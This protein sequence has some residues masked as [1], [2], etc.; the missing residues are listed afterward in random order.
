MCI[1]TANFSP[2]MQNYYTYMVHF[3][4]EFRSNCHDYIAEKVFSTHRHY[5]RGFR[6]QLN[7]T[8][9]YIQFSWRYRYYGYFRLYEDIRMWPKYIPT[10]FMPWKKKEDLVRIGLVGKHAL[11]WK[12]HHLK[13]FLSHGHMY[14]SISDK[15]M[16]KRKSDE[17]L[18]KKME[19]LER[20]RKE[21]ER[22]RKAKEA[23]KKKK[24]SSTSSSKSSSSSSRRL[25]RKESGP[26]HNRRRKN[27]GR[28]AVRSRR[29]R[30][31]RNRVNRNRRH[32]EHGRKLRSRRSKVHHSRKSHRNHHRRLM[33]EFHPR[34]LMQ[35]PTQPVEMQNKTTPV[36]RNLTQKNALTSDGKPVIRESDFAREP[37]PEMFKNEIFPPFNPKYQINPPSPRLLRGKDYDPIADYD[38]RPDVANDIRE[39]MV[40]QLKPETPKER[41]L[42]KIVSPTPDYFLRYGFRHV[43][44]REGFV[45][46]KTPKKVAFLKKT[47]N[48]VFES[49]SKIGRCGYGYW[50]HC[51][52]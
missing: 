37:E 39:E 14:P 15:E 5:W 40:G 25:R 3:K 19:E 38:P 33:K 30:R 16:A 23:A 51:T 44:S 45:I 4:I 11:R 31:R 28:R 6:I 29:R 52:L 13:L 10:T 17:I 46:A 49:A 27:Y 32:R 34:Y 43:N 9:F 2:L 26:R 21:E 41:R 47:I 50:S 48:Y 12:P 8:R 1:L 7:Q 42:K 20:K 18:R 24:N 36:D 35:M 22:K